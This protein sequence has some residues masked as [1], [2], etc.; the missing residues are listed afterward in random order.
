MNVKLIVFS[1][2][3]TAIV[4]A[5]LG[6]GVAHLRP[7]PYTADLY[8]NLPQ[9]YALVGA[10]AGLLIGAGQECLRQMQQQSQRP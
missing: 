6:L 4:G 10:V 1:A 7:T 3:I 2:V 5:V 8:Q 9:K